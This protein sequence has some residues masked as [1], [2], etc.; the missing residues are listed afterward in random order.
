MEEEG[1]KVELL[2]VCFQ[3]D[4]KFR[5]LKTKGG[6]LMKAHLKL[7]TALSVML[8]FL[9]FGVLGFAAPRIESVSSTLVQAGDSVTV[10]LSGLKTDGTKYKL[11][12][13][14]KLDGTGDYNYT[15]EFE[16]DSGGTKTVSITVGTMP[17]GLHPANP[18]DSFKGIELYEAGSLVDYKALYMKPALLKPDESAHYKKGDT[19]E[20]IGAGF[21]ADSTLNVEWTH[22]VAIADVSVSADGYFKG[23]LAIPDNVPWRSSVSIWVTTTG[24]YEGFSNQKFSAPATIVID[25]VIEVLDPSDPTKTISPDTPVTFNDTLTVKGYNFYYE[26]D[27]TPDKVTLY[28]GD[29]SV[30]VLD[31]SAINTNGQFTTT[32]SVPVTTEGGYFNVKA[33]G[34][35]SNTWAEYGPV[36]YSSTIVLPQLILDKSS[37]QNGDVITLTGVGADAEQV[38]GFVQC[39]GT[40]ESDRLTIVDVLVGESTANGVKASADG[41][42]KLEVKIE[43]VGGGLIPEGTKEIF[44]S[45]ARDDFSATFTVNPKLISTPAIAF[46]NSAFKFQLSNISVTGFRGE[47]KLN[48]K[49]GNIGADGQLQVAADGHLEGGS[50]TFTNLPYG[51]DQVLTITGASSGKS[52]TYDNIDISG[53]VARKAKAEPAPPGYAY[54][55]EN[56][57]KIGDQIT[58]IGKGWK[59]GE[60]I[61]IKF[62]DNPSDLGGG[63]LVGSNGYFERS[64]NVPYVT[65]S[66]GTI[67]V[68]ETSVDEGI[69]YESENYTIK[70]RSTQEPIAGLSAYSGY[71]G[72]MVTIY[73][74]DATGDFGKLFFDTTP[75]PYYNMDGVLQF[76]DKDDDGAYD[77][78]EEISVTSLPIKFKVPTVPGGAHYVKLQSSSIPFDVKGKAELVSPAAGSDLQYGDEIEVKVSGFSGT[79]DVYLA[80]HEG[81]EI[82]AKQAQALDANGTKQFTFTVPSAPLSSSGQVDLKFVGSAGGGT[83]TLDVNFTVIPKIAISPT[84]GLNGTQVDIYGYGFSAGKKATLWVDSTKIKD[85]ISIDGQGYLHYTYTVADQTAGAKTLKVEDNET[86]KFDTATF[87]V[88]G[89]IKSVGPLSGPPGTTVTVE[90]EGYGTSWENVTVEVIEKSASVSQPALT[91]IS[92]DESKGYYKFSFVVPD[93]QYGPTLFKVYDNEESRIFTFGVTSEI[94]LSKGSAKVGESVTVSGKGFV[95]AAVS[96]YFDSAVVAT[97]SADDVSANGTFSKSFDVPAAAKGDH[98]IRASQADTSDSATLTVNRNI[99]QAASGDVKVGDSVEIKGTGFEASISGDIKMGDSDVGDF[100]TDANGSFTASF[101]VPAKPAGSYSISIYKGDDKLADAGAITIVPKLAVYDPNTNAAISTGK[102]DIWIKVEGKGFPAN[103]TGG[104]LIYVLDNQSIANL[105]T[106]GSG[107]F[108]KLVKLPLG[109][110]SGKSQLRATIDSSSASVDFVYSGTQVG[111][112]VSVGAASPGDTVKVYGYGYSANTSVGQIK[113]GDV[114]VSNSITTDENGAFYGVEVV[115]PEIPAGSQTVALTGAGGST[116]ITIQPKIWLS[117]ASGP[118]GTEVLVTGKGFKADKSIHSNLTFAGATRSL[119]WAAEE[120][121]VYTDGN[122]TGT[123][124]NSNGS[125]A[126]KFVVPNSTQGDKP[127]SVTADGSTAQENFKVEPA[128]TSL[129]SSVKNGGNIIVEATGLP[130]DTQKVVYGSQEVALS[131]ASGDD[132][133]VSDGHVKLTLQVTDQ[134]Y[135]SKDVYFKKADGSE[136]KDSGDN[137]VKR[138]FTVLPEIVSVTVGGTGNKF[139][140]TVNAT[141]FTADADITFSV[142]GKSFTIKSAANTGAVSGSKELEVIPGGTLVMTGTGP[143][144]ESATKLVTVTPRITLSPSGDHYY[145]GTSVAVHGYG[146]IPG[147][148]VSVYNAGSLVGTP[149]AT[150]TGEIT[151]SFSVPTSYGGKTVLALGQFSAEA[152]Y[153]IEEKIIEVTPL[154]GHAGTTV[155]VRGN[156]LNPS[157]TYTITLSG[158]PTLDTEIGDNGTFD[159]TFDLTGGAGKMSV[160]LQKDGTDVYT[161]P[162]PFLYSDP[163]AAEQIVPE[164]TQASIGDTITVRGYSFPANTNLGY[165]TLDNQVIYTV[166]DAGAGQ[167]VSSQIIT[168]DNGAFEVKFALPAVIGGGHTIGLSGAVPTATVTLVPSITVSPDRGPDG[169]WPRVVGTGFNPNSVIGY[170]QFDGSNIT[171]DNIAA[172][173]IGSLEDSQIKTDSSGGFA[174][175]FKVPY[176]PEGDYKIKVGAAE[177][178]FRVTGHATITEITSEAEVGGSVT[179]KV[180]GFPANALLKIKIAEKEHAGATAG[181][182]GKKTWTFNLKDVP[183]GDQP[184]VVWTEMEDTDQ[185]SAQATIT[186]KSVVTSVSPLEGHKGETVDVTGTGYRGG[187]QLSILL[188]SRDL[189]VIGT[190]RPNG[191]FLISFNIP[192]DLPYGSYDLT[193]RGSSGLQSTY[194]VKFKID[195]YATVTQVDGAYEGTYLNPGTVTV[196]GWGFKEGETVTVQFGSRSEQLTVDS[197]G[198]FSVPFDL[199][200]EPNGTKEV[201]ITGSETDEYDLP[202]FTVNPVISVSPTSGPPGTTATVEGWGFDPGVAA[203]RNTV[204]ITIEN[205]SE[206]LATEIEVDSGGHFGPDTITIPVLPPG[207]YNIAAY[208]AGYTGLNLPAPVKFT[209]QAGPEQQIAIDPTSGYIGTTVKVSAP[210]G[211]FDANASVNIYFNGEVVASGTTGADGSL[212]EK[213]FVVAPIAPIPGGPKTIEAKTDKVTEQATF[214]LKPRIKESSPDVANIGTIITLIGDGMGQ[215]DSLSVLFGEDLGDDTVLKPVEIAYGQTSND[216]GTFTVMFAVPDWSYTKASFNTKVK[217]VGSPSG[218]ETAVTDCVPVNILASRLKADPD[219]GS[220]DTV[221]NIYGLIVQG[222]NVQANTSLGEV[223]LTNATGSVSLD[224]AG[225]PDWVKVGSVSGNELVTNSNGVIELE[226]K[227]SDAADTGI[228]L[229]GGWPLTISFTELPNLTTTFNVQAVVAVDPTE[230]TVGQDVTVTGSGYMPDTDAS[231]KLDD[232]ELGTAT[233]D[234]TGRISATITVPEGTLGGDRSVTAVQKVGVLTIQSAQPATLTVKGQITKIEP[235][236]TIAG[237][238]IT[239]EGNGFEATEALQFKV[240]DQDIPAEN[241]TNGVTTET[242]TFAATVILPEDLAEGTYSLTVTG[243]TSGIEASGS[244]EIII[245]VAS[246]EPAEGEVGDAVTIE[247][248]GFPA[249]T[250]VE[251]YFDA[252]ADENKVEPDAPVTTDDAGAFTATLTV[253]KEYDDG[254]KL[255]VKVGEVV[256]ETDFTYMSLIESVTVEI[257]GAADD[258]TAIKDSVI[259]V[260]ATLRRSVASGTFSIGD[261]VTDAEMSKV[262]GA[263]TWQGTYTVQAGDYAEDATVSVKMTDAVGKVSTAQA[264]DKVNVD[265]VVQ[266]TSVDVSATAVKNGDT[267]TFTVVTEAGATVTVDLGGLDST[268]TEPIALTESA[269]TAGTFTAD[270]TISDENTAQNGPYTVTV[271]AVDKYGNEATSEVTIELR[272]YVEFT[273]QVTGGLSLISIPVAL[274][275]PMM[276][277]DLATAIGDVTTMLRIEEGKFIASVQTPEGWLNDTELV[278]GESLLVIRP[279]EAATAEVKFT[280]KALEGVIEFDRGLGL[281]TMPLMPAEDMTLEDLFQTLGGSDKLAVLIWSQNGTLKSDPTKRASVPVAGG[282]SYLIFAKEAGSVAV[283]GN[284]WENQPEGAATPSLSAAD[285]DTTTAPV[286]VVNGLVRDEKGAALENIRVTVENLTASR[287]VQAVADESGRYVAVLVDL[288][289]KAVKVGDMIAVD[290]VD[291]TGA[292]V[293]EPIKHL[294]TEEDIARGS[295]LVANLTMRPVPRESA[296]LPN[297]PNPFNPETWMPFVLSDE[298]DVTIRIY[299][300]VGRLVRRINLGHLR[301]GYYLNRDRAAYWD[302]R[303]ELGEQVASGIYFYQIQAGS[304]TKTKRMV[305]LK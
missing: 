171:G 214:T 154:T 248:T 135:G 83:Y 43:L 225:H 295:V 91:A 123:K 120:N 118:V 219:E 264:A 241:V 274:N 300:S 202:N 205:V 38:V 136:V 304:F 77:A 201:K 75:I 84:S 213:S 169:S 285:M 93:T 160:K 51:D 190:A 288:S 298:A 267:I 277:S 157:D 279:K 18:D 28:F 283:S 14:N 145:V 150:S 223:K 275:T 94:S 49:I 31:T 161:Y 251:F 108:S 268:V 90:L 167:V 148:T 143:N 71:V 258:G 243:A 110:T 179:V 137:I 45:E 193:V 17:F 166:L 272:N 147:E 69:K 79:V 124:T 253:D 218:L 270:V 231:I 86:G 19:V 187:D 178:D 125:F 199:S 13:G 305:L 257:T 101:V 216:D 198:H 265:A 112:T 140:F 132:T 48:L 296:L 184:V 159:V 185:Q 142:G 237:G 11:R 129:T 122:W 24:D 127:V 151:A 80:Y 8:G 36:L 52:V 215:N 273:L 292:Y 259:T 9:S 229:I 102:G 144:S 226:F 72:D 269:E 195:R 32:I 73:G 232:V 212:S 149:Q 109:L 286:L 282:A 55:D 299:D 256:V 180:Q 220:V 291:P 76:D 100:S 221:V 303:N 119:T 121:K 153:T 162:Y 111:L 281:I 210:A 66:T 252:V 238:Q 183:G 37:G 141:G 233:A 228:A 181:A 249:G 130:G 61:I 260:T 87:T 194:P 2:L 209:V 290:A 152:G 12:V 200:Q 217:V 156:G 287:N 262:E 244:I 207:D 23:T 211:T 139:N 203:Y 176:K 172:D 245:A 7:L 40:A 63:V 208:Q 170:L 41:V 117:P 60:K 10:T 128:I 131:G 168:D 235:A 70:S 182:D 293:A 74:F 236:S 81:P 35:V 33:K 62:G 196:E 126:V 78:G 98:T 95:D 138:S 103:K 164:P 64:F 158:A 284:A 116:S 242:G 278:G 294:I 280:G 266:I 47:E 1:K 44:L 96:I 65:Q 104:Q 188:G 6:S 191:T 82:L 46:D 26:T 107:S 165:L 224:L 174:V 20:V 222:G 88:R 230:A 297:Y 175:K 234:N 133:D 22:G 192:D 113:I 302:G 261:L 197:T 30:K 289:G 92:T 53:N 59:A 255:L 25:P 29:V 155:R 50:V 4:K 206:P 39:N 163:E 146:F 15:D 250:A 89:S 189:G 54:D 3:K 58:V 67:K 99:T 97:V 34:D 105:E 57:V 134:S 204:S 68:Y 240:D 5:K 247:G 271:K 186:V 21:K 106:D 173:G 254:T 301:P 239:V 114:A 246:A 227:L 276:L 16:A 85:D 115:V 42:F 263:E 177:T 27:K 56:Y